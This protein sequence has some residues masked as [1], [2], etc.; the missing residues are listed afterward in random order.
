MFFTT[1]IFLL[2]FLVHQSGGLEGIKPF[3]SK[4]AVYLEIDAS[5]RLSSKSFSELSEYFSVLAK[6]KGGA[7]AF[8]V[9]RQ[10]SVAPGTDMHL[11]GHVVGD[12]LYTQ[13]GLEGIRVCTHDFRN[14]CSHHCYRLIS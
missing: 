9:L 5:D 1:N 8:E 14:A 13:E 2:G 7:H 4:G 10:A 3:L 12:T 6:D 11:L